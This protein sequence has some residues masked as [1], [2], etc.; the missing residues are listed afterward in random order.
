M[1]NSL[2]KPDLSGIIKKPR[3]LDLQSLYVEKSRG[4]VREGEANEGVLK[5]ER[6]SPSEN[7]EESGLGQGK[8]KRKN[9]KEVSLSS[10]EPANKKSK[11]SLDG[12]G[13]SGLNLG[14]SAFNNPA[15]K[16]SRFVLHQKIRGKNNVRA[17]DHRNLQNFSNLSVIS[18]SLDDNIPKRPRG[19]SRRKKLQST[20]TPEQVGTSSS[21]VSS[22][23][24]AAQI[25][26]LTSDSVPSRIPS[27]GSQKRASDDFKE[28]SSNRAKPTRRLKAEDGGLVRDN[29]DPTL[30]NVHRNR[31]KR[32]QSTSKK[33]N[34]ANEIEQS[35]GNFTKIRGELQ[36]DDEE[37]LEQNAARMLS[38]RFDPSCTGFTGNNKTSSMNGLS[39][40]PLFCQG[41]LNSSS[42]DSTSA[43]AAG[44]VLRPRKQHKEKKGFVRKRRH[45]YEIFSGDLDAYWVLNRRIKVFWPLDQS[46]YFGLVTN[47]DPEG[48]LHHVKYDDRDEEWINLHNERFKLL[49]LPS[50]VPGK[51]GVEKS[52]QGGKKV[53]DQDEDVKI[54]DSNCT[55]SYMDSEPIISWLARSTHRVKSSPLGSMKKQKTSFKAEK[56]VRPIY[57]DD[58]PSET[59]LC[60]NSAGADTY[61]SLG[62]TVLEDRP[63]HGEVTEKPTTASTS[64][65][66]GRKT[67]F[68]YFRRRFRNRGQGLG[69]HAE[70]SPGCRS[71]ARSVS[72]LAS[73][74]DGVQALEEYDVTLQGS[75][76]KALTNL[77]RD[78]LLLSGENSGLFKST[79]Q[80][81]K[82]KQGKLKFNFPL[83][84]F[85]YN[86]V[87]N[88]EIFW[89]YRALLFLQFGKV[90]VVWPK[91]QLEMLFVDN[92]VGL[93]FMLFEGYLIQA[94]SFFCLVLSAFHHPVEHV[95]LVDLQLPVTSI[96]F[97]LSGF[98]GFGKQFV[99]VV[100]NFL[101]VKNSKWLYLDCKLKKHCSI[102]KQ[103]PLADCTYDNIKVLQSGCD[104][105]VP[106]VPEE[107][108]M[109]GGLCWKSRQGSM[110][111]GVSNK[112]VYIDTNSS[113]SNFNEKHRKLPPFVLSFAAAPS[114]F[115]SLH[116]KLLMDNNVASMS[117]QNHNSMSLLEE[118]PENCGRGMD[119][120]CLSVEESHRVQDG[121][122][123]NSLGVAFRDG[124]GAMC[125]SCAKPK[126]EIDALSISNDGDWIKSSQKY[127]DSELIVTGAS[128]GPQGSGKEIDVI[129]LPKGHPCQHS[130]S[131]QSVGKSWP[132]FSENHSSP[133]RSETGLFSC[134]NAVNVQI[135]P[136][137]QGDSQSCDLGTPNS[138]QSMFDLP[139]N[140]NYLAIRSPNPTAPRSV[141][142]RNRHS[143]GSSSFG[144]SKMWMDEGAD[145]IHNGFGNGSRKPRTQVS[146]ISPFRGYDFSSKPRSH[147]RKARP[148]KRIRNVDEKMTTDGSGTPQ[149]QTELL[150]CEANLLITAGDRGW[151]ECGAQIRLEFVDHKDWRLLVKVSGA[152]K[153]SFKA[154]QF[155]Q[156][157]TTNRYTHAMMWKGGKDWIL[158]FPNR[159]QWTLFREMHE[160]CYNQNIRAATVK[161]IP[162]PGVRLIEESDDHPMQTLFVRSL[163]K[164]FQQ[165]ENDV[166]MALNPSR[167]LYDMDSEDDQWMSRYHASS[168]IDGLNPLV[169]SEEMFERTMDM[170]EKVAYSQQRD[171]FT[172]DEMEELV[173]GVGP[174]Q[175]I[176]AI[177]E[178][179][180]QK[181]QKKGMPL[182]RQFQPSLWERYQQQVK[183][184]ELTVHK[185]KAT[186]EKPPMFAFCL[187]PRGLEVLNKGPKHRSQRKFA[188][189]GHSNAFSRDQDGVQVFGR[190]LNRYVFGE[191]R[192]LVTGYN[193]ELSDASTWLQT[194]TRVLSPRDAISTGY[195]SMSSDGAERTQYPKLNR[196]KS[197]KIG[198]FLFPNDSKMVAVPYN[199]RLTSRRNQACR[200][201]MGLPEWPS[202]RQ[203][204]P[205]GSQRQRVEQLGCSDFNEFRLRD[206]SGAAQHASNMAKLKRE[207]AQR[208]LYRADLAM[209]KAVVALMTA[210]AIKESE[211]EC[212]EDG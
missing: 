54:G 118:G 73:V 100:Y 110:P 212:T 39:L 138:Q 21:K 46:W 8:K 47:Y 69:D 29:G 146:H 93:R 13:G 56:S 143:V 36:E 72:F 205:E 86:H 206:A 136:H 1:E 99:F 19:L 193:H 149:R 192:S 4:S 152:L 185:G 66:N 175:V 140:M 59:C 11:K 45:F 196:N 94:V 82:L 9:R 85:V 103:L 16:L 209:H 90:V 48:K 186:V 65:S 68:V 184:W 97:K 92:V 202:Q 163:P 156:P 42:F 160:E 126:E 38:S 171:D 148:H 2:E 190:K 25:I 83:H 169:I 128:V 63:A 88:A 24:S 70:E 58:H 210:E 18:D 204:Q 174:N 108:M 131:E 106:L 95:R 51:S 120:D 173:V 139:W 7:E 78:T 154:H 64:Y 150:S 96:R 91:V 211:K 75:G 107:P 182:I 62:K 201:N 124:A 114:F 159:S 122:L 10:F 198:K 178:H 180:Q 112:S 176:K 41:M 31:R 98:H 153:Y 125:L 50:E 167:V 74:V 158:E 123:E 177:H 187:R 207:K 144:Q 80:L 161:N 134:L 32:R 113:S 203:Y 164:Y 79:F 76:C 115:L 26:K 189:G 127:L 195:L 116:L 5:R 49:L 183:E 104:W 87:L 151:R 84:L 111:M 191:E 145:F 132:S 208:L 109:H 55:A 188:A 6:K 15:L 20:H 170:F 130:V 23:R 52:G 89:L 14:S 71:L 33:Q 172:S 133:D 34:L 27:E 129:V 101:E 197:K 119:V 155:L 37:N 61:K 102:T 179:W 40:V 43:D 117:F 162:I 60:V 157:G 137:S 135:P 35:V 166:E 57:S 22:E 12:V 165:V 181:R 121:T 200:W 17:P 199:Q 44:R 168:D 142:H 141:W 28:N 81:M 194:S 53:E 67:P 77:D 3:S 30:K 147:L 105:L